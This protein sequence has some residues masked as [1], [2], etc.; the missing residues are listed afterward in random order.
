MW[1]EKYRP[2]S[3]EEYNLNAPIKKNIEKWMTDFQKKKPKASNCLLLHGPPGSGK[4]TLANII[5]R[6]NGYDTLEYNASDFRTPK[7]IREKIAD[8]IGKKNIMSMMCMKKQTIGIIM[9][10]VDG[11]G[12]GFNELLKVIFPKNGPID[13]PFIC[14]TNTVDKKILNLKKKAAYIKF[15]DVN[16]FNLEKVA[17]KILKRENIEYDHEILNYIIKKAQNDYRRLI[18]ML[19]YTYNK[20]EKPQTIEQVEELLKNYD[21]KNVN[22]T[23]FEAVEALLGKYDPGSVD[24]H[25]ETSKSLVPMIMYENFIPYIQQN[26]LD[27]KETKRENILKIYEYFSD[28]DMFDYSVMVNQNL[29][30]DQYN[31]VFKCMAP[32]YIVNSMKRKSYNSF[33]NLSFSTLLNKMSLEYS[34]VKSDNLLKKKIFSLSNTNMMWC[35]ATIF[36]TL[37]LDNNIDE[38][39]ELVRSYNLVPDDIDKLGRYLPSESADLM[40]LDTRKKIKNLLFVNEI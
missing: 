24:K 33:N 4:T 13:T 32:S 18:I 29:E 26:K 2:K 1:V 39:K 27:D 5:L 3:L 16:K 23:Y 37:Y 21:K 40:S 38:L 22:N 36:L 30:L 14:I 20:A 7:I 25:Y 34:N 19:E 28:A 8:S 35:F 17:K 31:S 12:L 15:P 11:M 9:D 10:E 6:S